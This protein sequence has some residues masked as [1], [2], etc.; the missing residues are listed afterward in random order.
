MWVS[1]VQSEVMCS[2]SKQGNFSITHSVCTVVSYY[3]SVFC[4][5]VCWINGRLSFVRVYPAGEGASQDWQCR[6]SEDGD[7]GARDAATRQSAEILMLTLVNWDFTNHTKDTVMLAPIKL[8]IVSGIKKLL[9]V[10]TEPQ[11]ELVSYQFTLAGALLPHWKKPQ[12]SVLRC[13]VILF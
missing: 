6:R 8:S 7:P 9:L 2:G 1:P 4:L 13:H 3:N 11:N 12:S 10:W 5:L